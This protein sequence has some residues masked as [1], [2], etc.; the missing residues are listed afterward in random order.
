MARGARQITP[1]LQRGQKIGRHDP[2]VPRLGQVRVQS[3]LDRVATA[4]RPAEKNLRGRTSHRLFRVETAQGHE[5]FVPEVRARKHYLERFG[6]LPRQRT[7]DAQAQITPAGTNA[8]AL[9]F[10]SDVETADKRDP[11]VADEQF[12]VVAKPESL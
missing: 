7:F 8:V 3:P 6:Q 11:F 9:V 4:A 2:H 10:G 5:A 1:Q 12:A